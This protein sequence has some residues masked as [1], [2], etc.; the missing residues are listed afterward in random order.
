METSQYPLF[1]N[2]IQHMRKEVQKVQKLKILTIDNHHINY[3]SFSNTELTEY[4]LQQILRSNL[5]GLPVF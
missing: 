1:S 4:I 2:T 3:R 5:S